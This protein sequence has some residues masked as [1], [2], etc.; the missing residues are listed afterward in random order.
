MSDQEPRVEGTEAVADSSVPPE[1]PASPVEQAEA[2]SAA[3]GG[4]T[5]ATGETDDDVV[6]AEIVDEDK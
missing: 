4:T 6:D 1:E 5:G 2:D 3:A